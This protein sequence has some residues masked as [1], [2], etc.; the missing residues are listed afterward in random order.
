[1]TDQDHAEAALKSEL[2]ELRAA[3][4][5]RQLNQKPPV[6]PGSV[7]E[8]IDNARSAIT[9]NPQETRRLTSPE[10][11]SAPSQYNGQMLPRGE[12][13][14]DIVQEVSGT[15]DIGSAGGIRQDAA[16]LGR[17]LAEEDA[18]SS[19]QREQKQVYKETETQLSHPNPNSN[20]DSDSN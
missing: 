19:Q 11:R 4:I 7:Q 18:R 5:I 20:S 6:L 8:L 14:G 12:G 1:M 16:K 3:Q 17:L 10:F 9:T 15:C 13:A 2:S